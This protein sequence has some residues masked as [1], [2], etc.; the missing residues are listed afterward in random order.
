M[1]DEGTSPAWR[2]CVQNKGASQNP[3]LAAAAAHYTRVQAPSR[4]VCMSF[5]HHKT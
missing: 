2:P 4:G 1:Q 3:V 5:G